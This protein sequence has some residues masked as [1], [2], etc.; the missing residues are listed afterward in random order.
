MFIVIAKTPKKNKFNNQQIA[1]KQQY[2]EYKIIAR[3]EKGLQKQRSAAAK[4]NW[5]KRRKIISRR[6]NHRK[7]ETSLKAYNLFNI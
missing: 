5:S 2:S 6:D 1:D 3:R 7:P 4:L